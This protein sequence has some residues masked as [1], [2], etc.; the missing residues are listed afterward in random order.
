[1][2]LS[3]LV[4]YFLRILFFFH[5]NHS[6]RIDCSG[7][8]T[9]MD[10]GSLLSSDSFESQTCGAAPGLIPRLRTAMET[11]AAA[12]PGEVS[13]IE[14]LAKALQSAGCAQLT[15]AGVR[16]PKVEVAFGRAM[17]HSIFATADDAT[18]ADVVLFFT[19]DPLDIDT[20]QSTCVRRGGGVAP[21]TAMQALYKLDPPTAGAT[22]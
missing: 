17:G 1:M 7:N 20:K 10:R 19:L 11:G 15:A 12:A 6:D 22:A 4:Q 14:Q 3:T 2:S 21:P 9:T 18:T 5:T 16:D 8:T 13:A